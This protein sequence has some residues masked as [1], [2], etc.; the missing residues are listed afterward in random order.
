MFEGL[1]ELPVGQLVDVYEGAIPRL[2]GETA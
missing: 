2:L 1:F